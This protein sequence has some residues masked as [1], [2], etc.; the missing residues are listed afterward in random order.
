MLLTFPRF[1]PA[2]RRGPVI[3]AEE[4]H[5]PGERVRQSQRRL[6]AVRRQPRGEGE[7]CY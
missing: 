4:I 7:D 6:P 1:P 5:Q 2:D 3:P